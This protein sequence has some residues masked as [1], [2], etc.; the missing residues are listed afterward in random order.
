MAASRSVF[1]E[2]VSM[3]GCRTA[4]VPMGFDDRTDADNR[5]RLDRQVGWVRRLATM[6]HE[7]EPLR[8]VELVFVG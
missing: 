4:Q 1:A 6:V 7:T 8:G 3:E 5:Y 2:A